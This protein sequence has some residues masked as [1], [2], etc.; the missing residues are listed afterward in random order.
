ME[1]IEMN[2]Y[3]I[4]EKIEIVKQHLLPKQ[5]REHGLGSKSV[6]LNKKVVEFIIAKYTRES[7]VRRLDKEIA[8][9]VRFVAKSMVMEEEFNPKPTKEDI[10]KILGE[11]KFDHDK[12]ESNE[13]AV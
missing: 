8:N 7:G 5:L 13:V 12:Y 1:V 10:I 3:T 6:S 2:G 9:V 4:E 11:P